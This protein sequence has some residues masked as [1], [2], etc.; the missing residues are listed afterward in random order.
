MSED[1]IGFKGKDANLYRYVRNSQINL[2]DPTGKNWAAGYTL[3]RIVISNLLGEIAA[4]CTGAPEFCYSLLPKPDPKPAPEP[5]PEPSCNP[6]RQSCEP[7]KEPN[8]C[9]AT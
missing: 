3:I 2:N 5:T 6:E 4:I 8:Q 7:P 9:T 1:P